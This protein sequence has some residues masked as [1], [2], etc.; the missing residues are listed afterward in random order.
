MRKT[1]VLTDETKVL[2]VPVKEWNKAFIGNF[3]KSLAEMKQGV[4]Q[5]KGEASLNNPA[6]SSAIDGKK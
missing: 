4:E 1:E 2:G 6:K 3:E 5:V